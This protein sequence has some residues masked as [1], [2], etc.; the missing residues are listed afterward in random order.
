MSET[1]I[2]FNGCELN[3]D[4]RLLTRHGEPVA[5]EPKALEF[6]YYL[7]IHRDRAVAK[8]ELADAL[9]PD[10]VISDTVITQTVRKARKALGDDGD[11]QA[12]IATVR[13][14]GYRFIAEVSNDGET[15]AGGDPKAPA[16]LR[17]WRAPAAVGLLALVATLAFLFRA[18][19]VGAPEF[20]SVALVPDFE[21]DEEQ[22]PDWLS[23]SVA[24][25]LRST[26]AMSETLFLIPA[27]AIAAQHEQSATDELFHQRLFDQLGADWIIKGRLRQFE[28]GWRIEIDI[29]G[30]NS[31]RRSLSIGGEEVMPLILATGRRLLGELDARP[32]PADAL[33]DDPWLNETFHR[34]VHA[35]RRGDSAHALS[36]FETVLDYAPDFDRARY[37]WAVASRQAGQI[38][39]GMTVLTELLQAENLSDPRLR[40]MA[41]NALG[42][43]Y[44][45]QGRLEDAAEYFKIMAREARQAGHVLDHAYGE[46]NQ[47]MVASNQGQYEQAETHLVEAMARFTQQGYQPG[48]A[49]TSNSLGVL[50]WQRG[51]LEDSD[52]WHREALDIRLGLGNQRDIAQSLFNL[53]TIAASRLDW[54]E[55]ERLFEQARMIH[56]SLG[57]QQ[58]VARIMINQGQNRA[59][60]GRIADGHQRLLEGLALAE[61]SGSLTL[62][63]TAK[64]RLGQVALLENR[65]EQALHWFDQA[66]QS[67]QTVQDRHLDQA[68]RLGRIRALRRAGQ[69]HDAQGELDAMRLSTEQDSDEQSAALML[70][71]ARIL[72]TENQHRKAIELLDDVLVVLRTGRN[73]RRLADAAGAMMEAF[74][75][76]QD[77]DSARE[78]MDSL[79]KRVRAEGELL[80]LHARLA[81]QLGQ[82]DEALE[83]MASARERMDERWSGELEQRYL[84][85]QKQ[86]TT[87]TESH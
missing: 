27:S 30:R 60:I 6:I 70:E 87:A 32:I 53:G 10:R 35:A 33:L 85:W 45:H 56:Q 3:R 52:L 72:M 62:Q 67:H 29:D 82:A 12:I 50:A 28:A 25:V 59:W 65:P 15:V 73:Q 22:L 41:A 71:Q 43:S 17:S 21:V 7:I 8:D 76:I 48:R 23:H 49:T 64:N 77:F 54:D 61:E 20:Y 83:I 9:W 47:G 34:G 86:L 51:R 38:E 79:P 26:L 19:E 80:E 11:R 5:V 84:T 46:L 4:Q 57:N 44:W 78:L 81:W 16:L 31:E 69:L 18:P 40:R 24:D 1:V 63:I 74:L 14:Y 66:L 55:S 39:E 36:L 75:N 37:E 68:S 2:E 42:V 13:G 58:Q